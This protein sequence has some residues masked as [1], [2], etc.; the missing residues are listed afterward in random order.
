MSRCK[1]A[2]LLSRQRVSMIAANFKSS[3]QRGLSFEA[4]CKSMLR[5]KGIAVR[6]SST[7]QDIYDHVDFFVYARNWGRWATCD[8]KAMRALKRGDALQDQFFF[9]EWF[10]VTGKNG[11]LTSGADIIIFER[12][13]DVLIIARTVLLSIA[14][15]LTD[16]T[17]RAKTDRQKLFFKQGGFNCTQRFYGIRHPSELGY[18]VLLSRQCSPNRSR[19]QP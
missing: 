9:V 2:E 10:N 4:L 11:W 12:S 14:N 18:E 6:N 15:L 17:H 13:R 8:A 7:H 1:P 3:F 5:D 19:G 16:K